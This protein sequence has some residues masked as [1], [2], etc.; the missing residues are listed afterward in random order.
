MRSCAALAIL[1]MT[2]TSHAEPPP[3]QAAEHP[4]PSSE[5][6]GDHEHEESYGLMAAENAAFLIGGTIWYWQTA[7]AQKPDWALGWDRP[8]WKHKLTSLDSFRFD[9]NMLWTNSFGHTTQAAFAY[10]INRGNGLGFTGAVVG[11]TAFALV[12]EYVVEYR[13]YPSI[14]DLVINVVSGPAF[15]EPTWQ[16]GRYFRTGPKTMTNELLAAAFSPFEGLDHRINHRAWRSMVRPWHR[17]RVWGGAGATE[18]PSESR[19]DAILGADLEVMSSAIPGT[20]GWTRVAPG[21]SS[22]ITGLT[23]FGEAGNH[24]GRLHTRVSL[25]GYQQ[26]AID[27]EGLGRSVFVGV[28]TGM[29]Y[30]SSKLSNERD[31]LVAYHLIGPQFEVE[32]RTRDL[33]L[34]YQAAAYADFGLVDAFA[35]GKLPILDPSPPWD[36]PLVAHGYYFGLGGSVWNRLY[37]DRD[38]WR[39]DLETNA[40]HLWS[41]DS[42]Q[43]DRGDVESP[44]DLVDTRIYGRL[45]LGY[46]LAPNGPVAEGLLDFAVRRGTVGDLE[47]HELERRF[48][49]QLTL[50]W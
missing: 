9:S 2:A 6:H 39:V 15:G 3:D 25:A 41:I 14:N 24:G 29:T 46:A 48:G 21:A 34:G 1:A 45:R 31:Q 11:N 13:E 18:F 16:I 42:H 23:R 33:V 49:A 32:V 20:R 35:M 5:Q 17:F 44:K 27:D 12:W 4:A 37:V 43:Q 10:Q 47:R 36:S 7:S 19:I 40:H 38:R 26:R 8:S 30:E 28:G 50:P 22:R